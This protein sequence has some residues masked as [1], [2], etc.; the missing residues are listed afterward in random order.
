ME[1]LVAALAKEDTAWVLVQDELHL[2]RPLRLTLQAIASLERGL[3]NLHRGSTTEAV[4]QLGLA[5]GLSENVV[6][7][8]DLVECLDALA[9][10]AYAVGDFDTAERHLA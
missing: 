1:S 7:Q 5:A 3:I 9:F 8:A 6:A 2:T 4:T 10:A